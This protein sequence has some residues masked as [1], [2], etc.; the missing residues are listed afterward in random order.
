MVSS[1]QLDE[2]LTRMREELAHLPL[3]A[4]NTFRCPYCKAPPGEL[5]RGRRRPNAEGVHAPRLSLG[6]KAQGKQRETP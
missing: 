3:L 1:P 4:V 6:V 2:L 5:C